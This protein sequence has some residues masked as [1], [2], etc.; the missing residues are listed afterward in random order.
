MA[1]VS[2]RPPH[3]ARWSDR[4]GFILATLG[5]AVG[6]GSIWKFP[7]E[8]GEN[9]GAAFILFYLL[10]LALVVLP[11]MFAEFAIDRRGGGDAAA[12]LAAIAVQ[13]GR[14][15]RWRWLG[16]FAIATGFLILTFYAVIGGLIQQDGR[17]AYR[18]TAAG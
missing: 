4:I 1:R 9:G 5:A 10:G 8:V 11:L 16:G 18:L 3:T 15:G 17:K 13:A 2:D 12:S 6:L 14:S 7:Y